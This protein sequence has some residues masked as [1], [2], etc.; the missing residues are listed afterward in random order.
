M[1]LA[2]L[3]TTNRQGHF[4][5]GHSRR[6]FLKSLGAGLAL[7][8]LGWRDLLPKAHAFRIRTITAGVDLSSLDDEDTLNEAIDFLVA[9]KERY[10]DAGY[11]VQTI[12][13]A[14]Q[15]LERYATGWPDGTVIRKVRG[16]DTVARERNVMFNVGPVITDDRYEAALAEWSSELIA[17]TTNTS[18]T[19]VVASEKLG[20]H[21][22][23]AKAAGEAIARIARDSDGGG[24]NFRFAATANS[25]AGTPFFPAAYHEGA[26]AF[27]LGLESPNLL[28]G[29]I[30]AAESRGGIAQALADALDEAI[31]PLADLASSLER[32]S[33][34]RYSGL[35]TSPAPGLDASI[36]ETVE[37]LTGQPFGSP[38]TL[39]ACA[40]LTDAIRSLKAK[41][42]GYSG[43]MLPVLE[44]RVLA[45][46]AVEGRFSVNDILLYSAVCGTGLDVVPLPGDSTAEEL[47]GLVL[48]VAALSAKYGKPLSARLFPIPGKE[49]GDPITFDNPFLTDCVVM[50][51]A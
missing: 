48:D 21:H 25:P 42:C 37:L 4:N 31:A 27:A 7:P 3:T 44:D 43:L 13:V 40:T 11:E 50:P 20:V 30:S 1:R 19:V 47:G 28:S 2:A 29:V 8:L 24:G 39:A 34:R 35:D 5:V 18:H 17:A 36:G 51:I 14:T 45:R 46:R 12:R 38:S 15:P 22:S 10:V 41:S 9:A 23:T 26:P 16:L 6:S 49:P 33:G 32:D